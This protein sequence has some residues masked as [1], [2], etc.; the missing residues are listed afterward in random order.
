MLHQIPPSLM[1]LLCFCILFTVYNYALLAQN[2][3]ILIYNDLDSVARVYYT[4]GDYPNSV[5][6]HLKAIKLSKSIKNDSLHNNSLYSLAKLYKEMGNHIDAEKLL[7]EALSITQKDKEKNISYTTNLKELGL[8]YIEMG[9]YP[10]A[11]QTLQKTLVAYKLFLGEDNLTYAINLNDLAGVYLNM[12]RFQES[13]PLLLQAMAIM[14]NIGATEKPSY[15][16]SNTNLAGAYWSLGRYDET[17]VLLLRAL[18][19][20]KKT[21]GEEHPEYAQNLNNLASLY[22]TMERYEATEPLFLEAM[23]IRKKTLGEEHVAYGNSL[24]NLA[25]LYVELERYKDA[26]PLYLKT[27]KV[28]KV[29]LGEEHPYYAISLEGLGMLYINMK[30]YTAAEPL[31]LEVQEIRKKALGVQNPDYA[32][33]LHK[34]GLLYANMENYEQ[35]ERFYLEAQKIWENVLGKK[36]TLYINSL[37]NLANLYAKKGDFEQAFLTVYQAL[38]LNCLTTKNAFTNKN[39]ND[40]LNHEFMFKQKLVESLGQVATIAQMQELK[41]NNK[42]SL[43]IAYDA[44]QL[45]IGVNNKIKNEFT[46]PSDKLMALKAIGSMLSDAIYL[47]V[48][49]AEGQDVVNKAF[50]YAEQNKSILLGEATKAKDARSFGYLPDSIAKQE[51]NLQLQLNQLKKQELEA[52]DPQMKMQMTSAL[53]EL[54]IHIDAFRKQ[55]KED[56]PQ[57]YEF[58]YATTIKKVED[59]QKKLKKGTAFLEYFVANKT[60]YLI[61]ITNQKANLYTLEIPKD[62]LNNKINALRNALT[63]YHYIKD[64]PEKAYANYSE[65]A[66]WFYQNLLAPALQDYQDIEE[67]IIVADADLGHLPFETFLTKEPSPTY[68]DYRVLSYLIKDYKISYNYSAAL[69]HESQLEQV[70]PKNGKVLACAGSYQNTNLT[71][72]RSPYLQKF[73]NAFVDLPAAEKEV[74]ILS[75]LFEGKFLK[76]TESNEHFFK[77]NAQD[78]SIIHLAMHGTL[79]KKNPILS[80]IVF[81][82]DGDSLE[83]NF[84]QAYEISHLKLNAQLVTLSACETGYGRFEQGEGVISLA[85]AFM[86]AGVPS[87]IVSLWQVNDLSTSKIMKSFYENLAEGMD[88]ATALQQSKIDYLGIATGIAAHPAFWSPFIQLGDSRPVSLDKKGDSIWLWWVFGLLGALTVLGIGFKLLKRKEVVF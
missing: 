86:Y 82:E 29:A 22:W 7:K 33:V 57:Y 14:E 64:Y 55:L 24:N 68:T 5:S 35:A 70:E 45:A 31:M 23:E 1:R 37:N 9:R 88:K 46:D 47:E 76:N 83:D 39:M 19:I 59:I 49:L 81:T 44:T 34:L 72:D 30:R 27:I 63:D 53:N 43:Q 10:E 12:G 50:E 36:H 40:I 74:D 80:S 58:K 48:K 16:S 87:V 28:L 25:G 79:N 32:E 71:K 56:F 42:A 77:Q 73:R 69:W 54:G 17:E 52:I 61:G 60:V 66:Y 18:E 51:S 13:I 38:N 65:N 11:E 78:Y 85:R 20:T 21:L 41:T 8:L 3:N 15:S 62:S 26:E 84:L 75:T 6:T 4:E 2:S 67:L